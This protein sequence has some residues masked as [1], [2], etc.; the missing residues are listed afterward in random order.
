MKNHK[1]GI[2]IK[3]AFGID[4]ES[5]QMKRKVMNDNIMPVDAETQ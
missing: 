1:F 3:L 5:C 2:R 4:G